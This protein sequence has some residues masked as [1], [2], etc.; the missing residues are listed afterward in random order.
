[1][2]ES[3]GWC[4][5]ASR[6]SKPLATNRSSTYDGAKT[7]NG[8]SSITSEGLADGIRSV[9]VNCTVQRNQPPL[10][11]APEDRDRR[12]KLGTS[13]RQERNGVK[14]EQSSTPLPPSPIIRL[15]RRSTDKPLLPSSKST[16]V[17]NGNSESVPSNELRSK[18]GQP[19]IRSQPSRSHPRR[20]TEQKGGGNVCAENPVRRDCGNE[21]PSAESSVAGSNV[22]PEYPSLRRGLLVLKVCVYIQYFNTVHSMKGLEPKWC[23]PFYG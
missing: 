9:E 3:D 5:V 23:N 6:S 1:M 21:F 11:P 2:A 22:R 8:A 19:I 20:G 16:I 4:V 15:L 17:S 18:I 14:D 7:T 13:S 10:K 12:S